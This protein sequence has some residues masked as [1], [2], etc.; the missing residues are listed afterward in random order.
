[1]EESKGRREGEKDEVIF[2]LIVSLQQQTGTLKFLMGHHDLACLHSSASSDCSSGRYNPSPAG[3]S[4]STGGP[5]YD[6]IM[7]PS[8]FQIGSP[9][10]VVLRKV[11]SV[12]MYVRCKIYV[13]MYV[14]MCA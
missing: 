6:E 11:I 5:I 12:Y 8:G 14:C 2:V 3:I 4:P 13:C 7:A 10:T 1:M 9:K